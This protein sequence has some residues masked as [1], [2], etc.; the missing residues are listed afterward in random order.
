MGMH[1]L[2]QFVGVYWAPTVCPAPG[3][4]QLAAEQAEKASSLWLVHSTRKEQVTHKSK[5]GYRR[6]FQK[7]CVCRETGTLKPNRV[8]GAADTVISG[9]RT[10]GPGKAQRAASGAGCGARLG[11]CAL[12]E[13]HSRECAVTQMEA[14]PHTPVRVAFHIWEQSHRGNCSQAK[15]SSVCTRRGKCLWE[16]TSSPGQ[17]TLA[18]EPP[19]PSCR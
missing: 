7:A 19:L 11:P 1:S 10:P 2:T 12:T 16:Q 15:C 8:A 6:F 9:M 17:W 13:V 4:V 18:S 5:S 3:Q 14:S